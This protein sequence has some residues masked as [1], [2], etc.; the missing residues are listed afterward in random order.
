MVL[1]LALHGRISSFHSWLNSLVLIGRQMI[2]YSLLAGMTLPTLTEVGNDMDA[3]M[4]K[5]EAVDIVDVI[6]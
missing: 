5:S 3:R 2:S 6:Q 1:P 4:Q